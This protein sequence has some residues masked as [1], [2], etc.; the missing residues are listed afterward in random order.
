MPNSSDKGSTKALL[1]SSLIPRHCH[2]LAHCRTSSTV[3]CMLG[4]S[5]WYVIHLLLSPTKQSICFCPFSILLLRKKKPY[6]HITYGSCHVSCSLQLFQ[7][8]LHFLGTVY[9]MAETY[10]HP[11]VNIQDLGQW[12]SFSI[13]GFSTSHSR[14]D[15]WDLSIP[16]NLWSARVHAKSTL[17]IFPQ[18]GSGCQ[19]SFRENLLA[20]KTT[21]EKGCP[22]LELSALKT[23][24]EYKVFWFHRTQECIWLNVHWMLTGGYITVLECDCWSLCY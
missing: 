21:A 2:V 12:K 4:P 18:F 16:R 8:Q 13:P 23:S 10:Q 1:S 20:M 5:W 9:C 3:V 7:M 6:T 24:W 17:S 22:R 11:K 15:V 14:H 19:Q